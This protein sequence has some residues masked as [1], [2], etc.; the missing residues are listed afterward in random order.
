[1]RTNKK[2]AFRMPQKET[3]FSRMFGLMISLLGVALIVL[4][5]EF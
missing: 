2:G 4:S 1:M 5:V 3:W